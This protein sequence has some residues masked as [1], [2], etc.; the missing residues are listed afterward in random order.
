MEQGIG[1]SN[2]ILSNGESVALAFPS[3]ARMK[4]LSA[5]LGADLFSEGL[6]N[7]KYSAIFQ[8]E[9]RPAE[10]LSLCLSEGAPSDLLNRV[11]PADFDL[12]VTA[13]FFKGKTVSVNLS[14]ELSV[15]RSCTG[16]GMLLRRLKDMLSTSPSSPLPK[17]IPGE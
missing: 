3:L 17:E 9:N 1:E 16:S 7:V 10:I 8:D 11:T 15:L 12:I 4:K 5:L 14:G 6:T 13:F 2:V